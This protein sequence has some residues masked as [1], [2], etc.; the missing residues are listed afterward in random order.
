MEWVHSPLILLVQYISTNARFHCPG[1]QREEEGVGK[2]LSSLVKRSCLKCVCF[3]CSPC[4]YPSRLA[5]LSSQ[6]KVIWSWWTWELRCSCA[7]PP[8]P[9]KVY[10]AACCSG[11][12]THFV[13]RFSFA[14]S[15][16][17]IGH[18]FLFSSLG[19]I[20][21]TGCSQ[22]NNCEWPLNGITWSLCTIF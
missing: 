15:K 19:S 11:N 17:W 22:C 18:S 14:M 1:F 16:L 8:L 5:C 7:S 6:Q 9:E 20:L 10:R 4:L 13:K 2:S 12:T 3:R 21:S